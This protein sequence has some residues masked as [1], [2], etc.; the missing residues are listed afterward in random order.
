MPEQE[1]V[2]RAT[3]YGYAD[4]ALHKGTPGGGKWEGSLA[5]APFTKHPMVAK[6]AHLSLHKY[7][8][9]SP[10]LSCQTLPAQMGHHFQMHRGTVWISLL[11]VSRTINMLIP[12]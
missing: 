10:T 2:F 8:I 5:P 9:Y 12:G 4:C 11:S 1:R 3:V 6:G 7:V